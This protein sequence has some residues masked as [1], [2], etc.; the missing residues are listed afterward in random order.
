[1]TK[2]TYETLSQIEGEH[3]ILTDAM[4]RQCQLKIDRVRRGTLN[5]DEW[6]SFSV[7]Y[8]AEIGV[9]IPQGNYQLEHSSF[10]TETK[11]LI[12]KSPIEYETIITRRRESS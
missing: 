8:T 1:M 3:V 4:G 12:P 7:Y 10:D 5:D 6:T 9:R 2:F 11:F